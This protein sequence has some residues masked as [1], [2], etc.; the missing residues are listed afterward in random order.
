MVI[1]DEPVKE[2]LR[3][4][5]NHSENTSSGKGVTLQGAGG[6]NICSPMDG[7][8]VYGLFKSNVFEINFQRQTIKPIEPI[9]MKNKLVFL[10]RFEISDLMS[11][12]Q[13]RLI[14]FLKAPDIGSGPSE[15]CSLNAGS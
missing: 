14:K 3:V 5:F 12:S 2:E 15:P 7:N 1:W 9:E 8:T 10:G 13:H 11:P 6:L 4:T